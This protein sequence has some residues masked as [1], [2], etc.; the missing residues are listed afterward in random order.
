MSL[1]DGEM[2]TVAA[3]GAALLSAALSLPTLYFSASRGESGPPPLEDMEAIEASIAVRKK[4]AKQP[5]KKFQ[6]PPPE[7]KPEG[8]SRD[9][10]KKPDEKKPD[11]KKP[12]PAAQTDP[13]AKFRRPV[14]DDAPVGKP[15]EDV[16][17]FNDNDRGFAEETKGD[18]F[19]QRI[20]RDINES[21]EFPKI[22]DAKGAAIGCLHI[23]ADG[24]IAKWKLD[25]RSGDN[26]L[27]DS[28]ERALKKVEQL[29]NANP[30]PVPTHLLKKAT[31]R[32]TC[33]KFNPQQPTD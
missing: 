32:W 31:T 33:F 24:K 11:E 25:Q 8:V 4:P 28:V 7:V 12:T 19:F 27:D 13:L 17:N 30:E 3:V 14:D 16:G 18:P 20:A 10:N 22:L 23:Q 6:P 26:S 5:Q 9:E 15:T 29:R 2:H 1:K 21:W